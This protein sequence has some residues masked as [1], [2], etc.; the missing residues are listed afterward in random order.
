[1][2]PPGKL[3]PVEPFNTDRWRAMDADVKF[4]GKRIVNKAALSIHDLSTHLRMQDAVLTLDPLRFG[5]ANGDIDADIHLDGRTD[6]TQGRL[7]LSV[8]D[9]QLKKLFPT[10]ALMKNSAG[11]IN[12]DLALSATGNSVAALLGSSNGE[13][14]LLVN[15]G[16][17]SDMLME[18]A[19]LNVAN[20]VID[21]LFGD[22]TVKINCVA[23]DFVAR[24]GTLDSRLFVFDAE[25]ATIN[26]D[27][28]VDLSSE[29]LDMTLHPHSKGIRIL[30]LR[31]PL[32][33]RGTLKH[34]DVGVEKGPLLA[35]GAG[36]VVLG[37]VAAPLAALAALV[38][39][40]HHNEYQCSALVTQ[41]RQQAKAPAPG[42]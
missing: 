2:Q 18:E 39:P 21:K 15:G 31:S 34:P 17:I 27:G 5:V 8:R 25:N 29:K 14:K 4:T 13:V 42:K 33:V 11:S 30:S 9:L 20:I 12:G 26:I 7:R 23:A 28:T 24:N 36:A 1:M 19:G 3:L 37:T 41:M 22:H 40:S 38:A 16:V 35:R 32:Y 6:P 10:V